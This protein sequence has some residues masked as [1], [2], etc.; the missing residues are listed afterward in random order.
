MY[1]AISRTVNVQLYSNTGGL[2]MLSQTGK[3]SDGAKLNFPRPAD[4]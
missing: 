1:T 4:G 2:S 3:V